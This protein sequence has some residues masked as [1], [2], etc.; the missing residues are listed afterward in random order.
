[1]GQGCLQGVSPQPAPTPS[2]H[3]LQRVLVQSGCAGGG[4]R[5]SRI[6]PHAQ[7]SPS[8]L[9]ASSACASSAPS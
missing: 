2:P 8:L 7:A 4:A 9:Q 1:M 5:G 6:L 3:L